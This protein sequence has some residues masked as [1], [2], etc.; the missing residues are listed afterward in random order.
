[1]ANADQKY[2]EVREKA[3]EWVIA[4]ARKLEDLKNSFYG[5][6]WA[7]L[8]EALRAVYK[9]EKKEYRT[10]KSFI[11]LVEKKDS[12]KAKKMKALNNTLVECMSSGGELSR[13][14]KKVEQTKGE[15]NIY[16]RHKRKGGGTSF[17]IRKE[18]FLSAKKDLDSA[19]DKALKAAEGLYRL[20]HTS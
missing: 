20:V 16:A 5:E 11:S 1:M 2:K 6:G 3:E 7:R 10:V 4:E 9:A 14:A 19:I 15:S 13:A 17:A 12:V 8:D 18:M